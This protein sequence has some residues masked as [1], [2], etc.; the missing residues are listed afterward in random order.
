M[1]GCLMS[2]DYYCLWWPLML[3]LMGGGDVVRWW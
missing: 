1:R 2:I 3:L